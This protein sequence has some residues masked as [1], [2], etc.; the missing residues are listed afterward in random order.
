MSTPQGVAVPYH[1]KDKAESE[2]RK[3]DGRLCD[4]AIISCFTEEEIDLLQRAGLIIRAPF[5]GWRWNGR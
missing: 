5:S 4:I 1:L 2:F 3:K